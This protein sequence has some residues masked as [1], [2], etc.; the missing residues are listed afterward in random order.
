MSY[1]NL[2]KQFKILFEKELGDC[3]LNIILSFESSFDNRLGRLRFVKDKGFEICVN[4]EYVKKSCFGKDIS[5]KFKLYYCTL[6]INEFIKQ[7]EQAKHSIPQSYFEGLVFL[8]AI[9]VLKSKKAVNICFPAFNISEAKKKKS[10]SVCSSVFNANKGKKSLNSL[11]IS[12][13]INALNKIKKLFADYLNI[14]ELLYANS[15]CKCLMLFAGAPEIF[16]KKGEIPKYILPDLLKNTA[17]LIDEEP[18][19]CKEY[20]VLAILP[21]ENINNLTV[22]ELFLLCI[23]AEN[24]FLRGMA[25]RL[26]AFFDFSMKLSEAEYNSLKEELNKYI[27]YSLYYYKENSELSFCLLEDNLIAIKI[28][29]KSINKYLG[30]EKINGDYG[31][32]HLTE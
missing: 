25:V 1:F 15:L 16:Y 10:V 6:F 2:K 27:E 4:L 28:A 22:N 24:K 17:K 12:V 30:K 13:A 7:L 9:D 14:E 29:L 3:G 18:E 5:S 20:P 11:E 19:M 8:R 32:I 31:N 21:F 23:K 26:I